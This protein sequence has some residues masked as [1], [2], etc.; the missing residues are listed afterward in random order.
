MNGCYANLSGGTQGE[1]MEDMT[2][3]LCESIDLTKTPAPQ[4]LKD[5]QKYAKRCCLMGCSI[6]VRRKTTAKY[7]KKMLIFILLFSTFDLQSK[8]IEAKLNNGLIAGHAYSVTDV[9]HVSNHT[10]FP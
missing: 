5:L 9:D 2:G 7:K 8:E 3:G 4:L 1:A 10:N 6:T